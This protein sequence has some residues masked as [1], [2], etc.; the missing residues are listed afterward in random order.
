MLNSKLYVIMAI[1]I[2]VKKEVTPIGP[3]LILPQ[4]HG[5][6]YSLIKMIDGITQRRIIIENDYE[7]VWI[8]CK[9]NE[10]AGK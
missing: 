4:A 2:C 1:F 10:V 9:S 8:R 3:L 6:T 5:L 7:K